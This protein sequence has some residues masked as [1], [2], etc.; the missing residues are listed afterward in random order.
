MWAPSDRTIGSATTE[1]PELANVFVRRRSPARRLAGQSLVAFAI[2]R[3]GGSSCRKQSPAPLLALREAGRNYADAEVRV[4][5]WKRVSQISM[6]TVELLLY[7]SSR[8]PSVPLSSTRGR[9]GQVTQLRLGKALRD[10]QSAGRPAVG[11]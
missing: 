1:R 5:N 11:Y 3:P 6:T 8:R 4:T 7:A 2:A 10:T 9:V